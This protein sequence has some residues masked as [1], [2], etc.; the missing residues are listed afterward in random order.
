M[1]LPQ[2]MSIF[3]EFLYSNTDTFLVRIEV[4]TNVGTGFHVPVGVHLNVLSLLQRHEA[5]GDVNKTQEAVVSFV[6]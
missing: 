1:R 3:V 5:V 2:A 4:K 6:V